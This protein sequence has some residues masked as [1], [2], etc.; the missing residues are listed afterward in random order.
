MRTTLHK[1]PIK[2]FRFYNKSPQKVML[3]DES[4]HYEIL[5]RHYFG[6]W[7]P[8]P[9]TLQVIGNCQQNGCQ[10]GA[11]IDVT[12]LSSEMQLALGFT[13]TIPNEHIAVESDDG[14]YIK[15]HHT[16]DVLPL[17]TFTNCELVADTEISEKIYYMPDPLKVLTQIDIRIKNVNDSAVF[18]DEEHTVQLRQTEK[19]RRQQQIKKYLENQFGFS[20]QT[21]YIVVYACGYEKILPLVNWCLQSLKKVRRQGFRGIIYNREYARDSISVILENYKHGNLSEVEEKLAKLKLKPITFITKDERELI[22]HDHQNTVE[23]VE[24]LFSVACKVID[25]CYLFLKRSK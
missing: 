22:K 13:K 21:A 11:E 2:T 3:C 5:Y 17:N 7:Y 18:I 12:S 14:E 20:L 4:L 25:E 19:K 16:G 8:D 6:T 24:R 9:E 10:N 15:I 1:I 23:A